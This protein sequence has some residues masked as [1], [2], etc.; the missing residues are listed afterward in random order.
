ME[1]AVREAADQVSGDVVLDRLIELA[2]EE[3]LEGKPLFQNLLEEPT[4]YRRYF[5]RWVREAIA[6]KKAQE[7]ATKGVVSAFLGKE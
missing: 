5:K 6:E 4:F 2:I 7:A 3:D 1:N